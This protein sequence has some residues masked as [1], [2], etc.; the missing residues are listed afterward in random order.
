MKDGG[1]QKIVSPRI[2]VMKGM[3]GQQMKELGRRQ[4]AFTLEYRQLRTEADEHVFKTALNKVK[5]LFTGNK[6]GVNDKHI[7]E[8][9]DLPA[10]RRN[11]PRSMSVQEDLLSDKLNQP[12]FMFNPIGHTK[13]AWDAFV[14]F[15]V[16][17]NCCSVPYH[18][19]LQP[20]YNCTEEELKN[21]EY[22]DC[23][24]KTSQNFDVLVY[25][26]FWLDL[27]VQ[28]R[29]GYV[30][31]QQHIVLNFKQAF[32][33]YLC[34]WFLIDF[35]SAI[36]FD[37]IAASKSET[38]FIEI[39]LLQMLKLFK[40]A[41]LT[42]GLDKT[43]QANIFRLVRVILGLMML[44]HWIGCM[45]FYLGMHQLTYY[46][47][48]GC[49]DNTGC[50]WIKQY[51]MTT[52]NL[53]T[54]YSSSLY[55]GMTMLTSV[56]F[57]Y[58]SPHT[59]VEK[60]FAWFCQLLGAIITAIIFGE[61]V[62]AVQDFEGSN[63]R[64]RNV[65]G[66][67]NQFLKFY[68]L[69]KDLA[70]RVRNNMEYG[71]TLHS[72]M[73]QH[74]LLQVL[75][76]SLRTEVLM[77]VQRNVIQTCTM[78][79]ECDKAFIKAM[80]L[81]LEPNAYLPYEVVYEEGDATRDVYFVSRGRFKVVTGTGRA[82]SVLSE[83]DY[84]GE[85]SYFDYT[86]RS[87]SVVAIT[88]GEVY[89]ITCTKL[90]EILDSFPEYV[91]VLRREAAQHARVYD[92]GTFYTSPGVR[93]KS[94]LNQQ[95]APGGGTVKEDPVEVK[96]K[97]ITPWLETPQSRSPLGGIT[98]DEEMTEEELSLT[99]TV[100]VTEDDY[101]DD[102]QKDLPGSISS[103]PKSPQK[104]QL[105]DIEIQYKTATMYSSQLKKMYEQALHQEKILAANI[106]NVRQKEQERMREEDI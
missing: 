9:E 61:V 34:G 57:G 50:P 45:Y 12:T 102:A 66:R 95:P 94:A 30:N 60:F 93:R 80:C 52:A 22:T 75:P 18:T 2:S 103:P 84:F 27:F 98:E 15:F 11:R 59:N 83:G 36:P 25:I 7:V 88:Y 67:T 38:G 76:D 85:L 51:N 63:S 26:V 32:R 13:M 40:V 70:K 54:Q 28:S 92:K 74:E 87:A 21:V 10:P 56:E 53:Y 37:Y 47:N 16:I 8:E 65:M 105:T 100:P 33:H 29:T 104:K 14:M 5:K 62:T 106:Q 4:S 72:G 90:D 48:E 73:D 31:D 6:I 91:S 23:Y 101:S 46:E 58:V 77:H 68:N 17:W 39:R 96:T 99:P 78:F 86:R 43:P 89:I 35:A 20:R 64:Y 44:G 49:N 69:P 1:R 3:Q 42:K 41:P 24:P 81:N 19:A 71:W 82:L 97:S 79:K 55:W